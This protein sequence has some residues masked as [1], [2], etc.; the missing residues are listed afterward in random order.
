MSQFGLKINKSQAPDKTPYTVYYP[1]TI[2]HTERKWDQDYYEILSMDPG[3]VKNFAF[4]IERRYHNGKI[5]PI[6]FDKVDFASF[7][8]EGTTLVNNTYQVLTNFLDKY[9]EFYDDCHF[10]IIERQLPKNYK[11]VRVSQHVISYFSFKMH[12]RPL[13]PAIVEIESRLKGKYLGA[14]TGINDKQLKT[15]SVVKGRELL[16]LRNDTFSLQVLDHFKNKQDDLCDT[17]CQLEALM[18]CWGLPTTP[19]S[20]IINV[21]DEL[22]PNVSRDDNLKAELLS[23]NSNKLIILKSANNENKSTTLSNNP[24]KSIILKSINNENKPLTLAIKPNNN[25][26]L[27]LSIKP[28]NNKI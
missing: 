4:R 2:P 1:H 5:I 7:E 28:N 25:K 17:I 26:P 21:K 15:W 8:N 9:K 19:N 13:L 3:K 6:V 18:I 23:N 10:F 20:I 27:T 22:L 16:T 12:N 24:N 14:P 11:A